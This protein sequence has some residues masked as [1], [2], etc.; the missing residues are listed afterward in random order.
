MSNVPGAF[1]RQKKCACCNNPWNLNCDDDSTESSQNNYDPVCQPCL[2]DNK[3]YTGIDP[4]NFD[5]SVSL[6]ENF[7]LWSNG[8]WRKKN[9]I[10]AEYSSWN[11]FIALRDQNLDRLKAILEELAG[12]TQPGANDDT[13]KLSAFYNSFM[14]ETMI[15]SRGAQSLLE[16]ISVCQASKVS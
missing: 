1:A 13:A 2:G 11:T 14:D 7:Y 8:G 4:E 6:N 5:S 12:G 3:G 16:A 9:P 10:P 15:E